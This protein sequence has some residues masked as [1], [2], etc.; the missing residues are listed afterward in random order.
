MEDHFLDIEAYLDGRMSDAERNDFEIQLARDATLLTSFEEMRQLRGDLA[1]HYAL[2]DVAAAA[3]MR[4]EYQRK[5]WIWLTCFLGLLVATLA[6]IFIGWND[7]ASSTSQQQ[8]TPLLQL[9]PVNNAV[10]PENNKKT[11]Q[12][13]S[14]QTPPTTL[15]IKPIAGKLKK[16]GTHAGDL[17]RDLPKEEVPAKYQQFFEQ[18]M[19]GWVPVVEPKGIWEPA[20]AALMQGQVAT[21]YNLLKKM[22]AALFSNDTTQYLQ[23]VTALQMSRPS[24]AET[25]LY[26]LVADKKW[27]TE[28]HYWL[29]WVYLLRGEEDLAI[30][31]L[32]LL[33]E[34]YR[35]RKTIAAF[36]KR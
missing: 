7:G 17:Y 22:P 32:K 13:S 5:R 29:V 26:P 24:A 14:Q 21:A 33:P 4:R 31:A 25:L 23:A 28:G 35:D 2:N 1:W 16:A 10:S 15:K 19:K 8:T 9:P 12:G 18:Q 27:E 30:S 20:V 11:P 36:L 3:Q 34:E 6:G